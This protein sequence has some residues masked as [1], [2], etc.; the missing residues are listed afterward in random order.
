MSQAEC[1][2]CEKMT[3]VNAEMKL[4]VHV[5]CKHCGADTIIVWIN[6]LEL[7]L[8]YDDDYSDA[9]QDFVYKDDGYY[10]EDYEDYP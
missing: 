5:T 3:T 4:G 2:N 9:E 10:D 6:P 8:L 1:P 7:D